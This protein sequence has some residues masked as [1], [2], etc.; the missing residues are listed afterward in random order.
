VTVALDQVL[1]FEEGGF[2]GSTCSY[3]LA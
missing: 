1:A 3:N 2:H